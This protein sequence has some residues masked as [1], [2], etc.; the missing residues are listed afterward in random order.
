[1]RAGG[2][3]TTAITLVLV[4]GM[5]MPTP[6]SASPTAPALDPATAVSFPVHT[7]PT[8]GDVLTFP[9][10]NFDGSVTDHGD[11][12]ILSADVFFAYNDDRLSER[13][14]GELATLTKKLR[15]RSAHLSVVGHTDSRG[16][17][18]ANL[19]LSLRRARAVEAVLAAA[20]SDVHVDAEGRGETEPIADEGT[21]D[22]RALN[23]R[24]EIRTNTGDGGR[25]ER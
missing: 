22:G 11:R 16:S 7:I 21:D 6:A 9:E 8:T 23:R 12:I 25:P 2:W 19:D 3:H 1:M 5:V 13:A 14:N 15:P 18:T 20:L 10:A 4:S 24:V 17:A